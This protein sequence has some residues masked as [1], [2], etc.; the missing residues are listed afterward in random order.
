MTRRDSAGRDDIAPDGPP[1]V[2]PLLIAH[3]AGND[4]AALRAAEAA[5]AD[6]IETD[7]WFYRRRIELRHLKTLGPLPVL[8]D[9][10]YLRAGWGPRRSL[11][12]LL[13]ELAPSTGVLLD[14]KGFD[15]RLAPR[16]LS[17]LD[18]PSRERRIVVCSRFWRLLPPFAEH[19]AIDVIYSV[20]SE[21][22]LRR[23]W[24]RIEHGEVATISIHAQLLTAERVAAF[25][26]RD[27]AVIPWA[28]R[29]EAHARALLDWGVDG[30]NLDD[31]A[32]LRRLASSPPLRGDPPSNSAEGGV[33]DDR[34]EAPSV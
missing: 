9:R 4:A 10:W 32:L 27:V 29:D 12:Q 13:G 30:V 23:M 8:W 19:P 34:G 5:G 25:R 14:L 26:A 11:D 1:A 22:Q 7:V 16:L 28:V 6:L 18:R 21:W 31:P 2:R 3:R 15:P 33:G 20:G 17:L 24:R